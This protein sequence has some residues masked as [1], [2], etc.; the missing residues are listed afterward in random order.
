MNFLYNAIKK[1]KEIDQK[2]RLVVFLDNVGSH[3][4]KEVNFKVYFY[5]IFYFFI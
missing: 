5:V 3:V 4:K 2:Q 1:Y